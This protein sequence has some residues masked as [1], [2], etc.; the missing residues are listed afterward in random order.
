M[1]YGR[2]QDIVHLAIRLQ[3]ARHG[4]T[5]DDIQEEFGVSRRTAERL[6]DAVDAV[7]G[8]LDTVDTSHSRRHRQVCSDALRQLIQV[9]PEELVELESAA[10]GLER[11]GLVERAASL[12]DLAGKL[13]AMGRRRSPAELESDVEALLRAEGLAMRAGPRPRIEEGLLPLL[14]EALKVGQMIEFTYLAQSTGRRSRQRVCPCGV[15][16]GNRA[17]LVGR[18][19]WAEDLR[20]WRLANMSKA[21]LTG[22]TF[23][24]DPAFDLRSHARRWVQGRAFS[25]FTQRSGP[26]GLNWPS[27]LRYTNA[28][29]AWPPGMWTL[30]STHPCELRLTGV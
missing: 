27:T 24:R 4:L 11:S 20:L 2:L 6:R 5:L 28:T 9:S 19:D 15:L 7:F 26:S 25:L 16:Y 30:Y 23:E 14:R 17:F 21:R 13:R 1:R 10:E 29:G 8:P 22:E 18:A 3:G 12:R